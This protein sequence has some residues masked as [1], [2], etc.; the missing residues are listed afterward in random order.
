MMMGKI[1]N[2]GW[3]TE[4]KDYTQADYLLQEIGDF[5]LTED[6][7]LIIAAGS[8]GAGWNRGEK[9]LGT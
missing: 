8:E 1:T 7:G 4:P 9:D 5:L 6:G 2:M 3:N